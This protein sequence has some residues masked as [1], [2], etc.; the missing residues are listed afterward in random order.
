MQDCTKFGGKTTISNILLSG[1]SI[2]LP[3]KNLVEKR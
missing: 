1:N 2:L 3:I